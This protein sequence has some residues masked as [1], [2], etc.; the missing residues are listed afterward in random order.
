[1]RR[2][3]VL[4]ERAFSDFCQAPIGDTCMVGYGNGGGM[5]W[6]FSFCLGFAVERLLAWNLNTATGIFAIREDGKSAT[7]L[8]YCATAVKLAL[9]TTYK[10]A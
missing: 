6:D 10:C 4:M 8:L 2:N 7:I 1:M 9:V 3:W 5:A